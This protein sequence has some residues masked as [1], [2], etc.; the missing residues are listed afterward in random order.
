MTSTSCNEIAK[1]LLDQCLA[2]KPPDRLP[3][4]LLSEPCAQ[5]LFGIWV[6]GLADRFE[7]A[8]C[9]TYVRLFAQAV[10]HRDQTVDARELAARYQRIR[11]VRP[12]TINPRRVFVLSRVTLGAEVA[13]TSVLMAAAC[14]PVLSTPYVEAATILPD[15]NVMGTNTPGITIAMGSSAT[16]EVKLYSDGNAPDWTV[17]AF[18]IAQKFLK[19]TPELTF[20]FDKTTGHNGDT[21][22]MTITRVAP[23]S[24]GVSEIQLESQVNGVTDGTWF[25]LVN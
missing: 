14:V 4:P 9:D 11:R 6:E 21:L 25:T 13:V 12:A 5:A 7:P 3:P 1:E 2:G 15:I 23:P 8:L 20:S 22:Q 16:V 24:Q 19:T 10:A 18:D 17:A